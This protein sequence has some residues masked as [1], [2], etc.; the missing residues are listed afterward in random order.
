MDSV[1][2]ISEVLARMD[3]H[4]TATRAMRA[5]AADIAKMAE[6]VSD[7]LRAGHTLLVCGNGGSAADSQHLAAE[8]MGRF[9]KERSPWPAVSLTCDTSQLT[10][11]GNDY[12]FEYVFARQIFALGRGG[13]VLVAIST[14]GNSPNVLSAIEAAREVGMLVVGMTGASGGKMA[15]LCDVCLC[16]PSDSTPRIQE[17]HGLAIHVVCG[18]VEDSL[19]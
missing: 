3:E 9:L 14:S 2:A 13:G 5:L 11:I 19:C 18:L 12:G 17:C 8:I 10:A 6:L 4:D 15:E 16:A 7:S 1:N